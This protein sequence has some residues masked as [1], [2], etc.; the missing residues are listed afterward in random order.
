MTDAPRT[1]AD[2]P[3]DIS[4]RD[5]R[6]TRCEPCQEEGGRA[7]RRRWNAANPEKVLEIGQRWRAANPRKKRDQ[8]RRYYA[9]HR[10]KIRKQN[11]SNSAPQRRFDAGDRRRRARLR[12]GA[13]R[14][15]GIWRDGIRRLKAVYR[16]SDRY[17][18]QARE[19]SPQAFPCG[20]RGGEGGEAKAERGAA[21]AA[22]RRP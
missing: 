9:A 20:P 2:C 8:D 3:A 21:T 10:E 16:N 5:Y 1:C 15:R 17:R 12:E 13:S 7:H 4:E 6:A 14:I 22:V 18:E 19:L 11:H